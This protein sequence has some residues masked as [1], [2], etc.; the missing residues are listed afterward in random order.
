LVEGTPFGRYLLLNVIGRGGMGE[1]WRAHD[2]VTDRVLAI[3]V[4]PAQYSED[5]MFRERFR[6]EAH[7]AARLNSPHVIPIYD[8]GEIDGRLFVSM[9]LIEGRDLHSILADGPLPPARAVAIIDQVA[10][11]L[12]AAHKVNLIHRDVKP[13]NILVDDDGFAYLIDFGI[14]R[15]LDDTRLTGTGAAI[16][17]FHYMAPERLGSGPDDARAD[18][19]ALTCVLYECLTGH[20]P[21]AGTDMASLVAAHLSTPPPHPSADVVTLPKQFDAV[22]ERGMAKQPDHRYA[23]AVELSAAA[24]EATT[25]PQALAGLEPTLPAQVATLLAPSGGQPAPSTP[26]RPWWTR[27]SGVVLAAVVSV[28]VVAVVA[29]TLILVN[30]PSS[31]SSSTGESATDGSP[32]FD[33]AQCQTGADANRIVGCLIVATGNSLDAVWTNLLSDYVRPSVN[34]FS[35]AVES[36]CGPAAGQ[37][38]AFYCPTDETAYFDLAFF[39][40]LADQPGGASM[41]FAQEYVVAHVYG[42]HIQKLTGDADRIKHGAIRTELQADCYAGV[43]AHFASTTPQQATGRPYLT[44]L[45]DDDIRTVVADVAAASTDWIDTHSHDLRESWAYGSTAQ[46]QHWLTVGYRSGDPKQC[47]TFSGAIGGP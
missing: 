21:F 26:S 7:A 38:G 15:A 45:T 40:M 16:G 37:V 11:A 39:E 30:R 44:P 2:T 33:L 18:I 34:L 28:V 23:T 43:W 46:R 6:R 14:A 4:L 41:P 12:H 32:P 36:A 10:K 25:V 8:Y 31:P 1:V 22:I 3:K 47:D 19:Y 29:T 20:P 27:R 5:P 24:R 13:S 9:R 35:G 42:H 17:T